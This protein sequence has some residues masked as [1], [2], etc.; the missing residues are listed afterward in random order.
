MGWRQNNRRWMKIACPRCGRQISSN[1]SHRRSHEKACA[2]KAAE[3]Q[4]SAA[5]KEGS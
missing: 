3:Q 5:R 1:P 4:Q 2:R